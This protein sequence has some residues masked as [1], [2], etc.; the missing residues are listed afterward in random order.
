MKAFLVAA[1]L[2]LS[3]IAQARSPMPPIR[4]D[5]AGEPVCYVGDVYSAMEY[6]ELLDFDPALSNVRVIQ[7]RC[8][9]SK[10]MIVAQQID[11]NGELYRTVVVPQCIKN[12]P[13][14]RCGN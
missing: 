1:L 3:I 10:P 4:T 2:G 14:K 9:G 7:A 5:E 13:A 6:L 12:K 8:V 11:E